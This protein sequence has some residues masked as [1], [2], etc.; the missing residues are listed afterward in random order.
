MDARHY[1]SCVIRGETGALVGAPTTTSVTLQLQDSAD[2]ATFANYVP[3]LFGGVATTAAIA[4][5]TAANSQAAQAVDLSGA[6]QY[7]R[8]QS[9]SSFTGGASPQAN[10]CGQ[11]IFGGADVKPTT[12]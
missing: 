11:I 1:R 8:I 10:L 2:N 9:V 4:P 3:P 5:L 6:R 12:L 7:V